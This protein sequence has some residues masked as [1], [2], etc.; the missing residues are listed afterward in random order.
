M[1]TGLIPVALKS[2][3]AAELL[4]DI[5]LSR[6]GTE[7]LAERTLSASRRCAHSKNASRNP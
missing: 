3:L 2:E 1:S 7:A 6:L 5:E 4:A